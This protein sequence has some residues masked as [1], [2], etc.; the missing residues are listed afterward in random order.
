MMSRPVFMLRG[1]HFPTM[2]VKD[3]SASLILVV[4]H[5]HNKRRKDVKE[6][7]YG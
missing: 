4:D 1:R 3:K 7:S 5:G 6:D 2:T